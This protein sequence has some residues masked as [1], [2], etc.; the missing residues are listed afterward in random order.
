[1]TS[2]FFDGLSGRARFFVSLRISDFAFGRALFVAPDFGFA[3]WLASGCFA[4]AG[5]LSAAGCIAF[6][7]IADS[8]R[9]SPRSWWIK[10][11]WEEIV[12][13]CCTTR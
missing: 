3:G 4:G 11:R 6:T 8:S 12:A 7:F 10:V 2:V 13:F 5:G 9:L 1:M